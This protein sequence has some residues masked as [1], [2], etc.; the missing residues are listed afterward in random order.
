MS[1]D[2]LVVGINCYQDQRLPN[3]T[4]P[5]EDAEAIAKILEKYGDFK[6]WRLP[7]AI[8]QEDGSSYVGKTPKAKVSKKELETALGQLFKPEGRSIP[9]TA[10]FYFS[11]HGIRQNH[12]LSEGFLATSDAD[13]DRG[14][15]GVSLQWLR[16]LL[17]SSP[18]KQQIIWLDCCYSGELLNLDEANP[19]ERGIAR[20]RCFIA[21][22]REFEK[23]YESIGSKYSVLTK[24]LLEGIDPNPFPQR[25]LTTIDL[26]SYINQNLKLDIQRPIYTNFG[27]P[28]K[29]THTWEVSEATSTI[30]AVSAICPYKGLAYFD[31]NDED[32]KYFYGRALLTNQLLDKVRQSNFLALVG[33]SG[34]G[35]SSVLRAG[36]LHQLKLGDCIGGS[37]AWE[38]NI[39]VPG[40]HPLQNLALTFVDPNLDR[41]ER[42]KKLGQAEGLLKEGADG[43]RHLVLSSDAPRL[44]LVVDQFEESFTLCQ[45]ESERKNFFKCLLETLEPTD[46]KYCLVIAM[47]ADFLGKCLEQD[48]S[49]LAKKIEQNLVTVTPM[50][51]AQLRE[52]VIKP[53]SRVGIEIEPE[54]VEQIIKDV[55][56]SPGSLP[57]LEYTLTQLWSQ[58][59]DNRLGLNAYIKIGGVSGALDKR[60]TE[61]YEQFLLPKQK[62][63]KQVQSIAQ[64]KQETV[65]HIFLCLTQLGEGTEDTRRRVAQTDLVTDKHPI[66]L[67]EEVIQQLAKERLVITSELLAKGSPTGRITV[68][69][70][71]HEALIRN[72]RLLRQWL[73][74]SRELLWQQ[75]KI[76]TAAAEWRDREKDKAKDYL[77]RGKRLKEARDF[78]KEQGERFPLSTSAKNFIKVSLKQKRL[79]RFKAS[80]IFLV[81]PIIGTF[82]LGYEG[83][84]LIHKQTLQKCKGIKGDCP[85]RI[86]ALE[87]LTQANRSLANI[88]LFRA[89]LGGADLSGADLSGA[90][91]SSADLSGA[92]LS[93]ANFSGARLSSA[94]LS[95]ADLSSANLSDAD[96]SSA[97]FYHAN[98]SGADLSDAFLYK[99][100]LGFANL[101]G[102]DLKDA[103][104]KDIKINKHTKLDGKWRRVWEIVNQ[105]AKNRNL[106]G[107]DLS[108]ANLYGDLSGVDLSGADLS[109]ANLSRISLFSA[110]LSGADLSG[111]DLSSA[112]LY[113]ADLSGADLSGADLSGADL[114]DTKLR[115]TKLCDA[116]LKDADLKDADLKD[117]KI[118]EHTKLDGKWRRVWEIANE[119]AKNRNLSGADLSGA[120]LSGADLSGAD[121][122]DA[123]LKDANLSGANLRYADLSGANLYSANFY[124]AD[125]SN[126]AL[127]YADLRRASL[128]SVN[129]SGTNLSGAKLWSANL[130]DTKINEHTNLDVKWRRV[131]EIVNQGAKNRNLS[132]ADLSGANLFYGDLSGVDLSGADLS[133]ANLSHADLSHAD[134]SGADL[135]GARLSSANLS[136]ANFSA[137]KL[138]YAYLKYTKINEHTKFDG[139][140]RRVWEIV[141][142]GAKNRNLSGA[143]LSR[144][145]LSDTNFYSADLS[146]AYLSGADLSGA[147][148]SGADLSGADL[149][150]AYLS[151]AYL[152][153]TKINENTKLDGKWRKVWEI[154][155]QGAKNRNL[156]G[157]DLSGTQLLDADLSGAQL[158]YGDL[159][160]TNFYYA[161]LSGADLSGA[162]L[163]G[164]NFYHAD[165]SG[166]NLSGANLSSAKLAYAN[167]SS[168]DLR[169]ADLRNAHFRG[170]D[171]SSANLSSAKLAHADLRR[172][173]LSGANLS[174]AKLAYADLS[175]ASLTEANLS[176]ANLSGADFRSGLFGRPL[177]GLAPEQIKKAK[178][179]EKAK[180]DPE[181]RQQLGLPPESTL[182]N[183]IE[184]KCDLVSRRKNQINLEVGEE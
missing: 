77:L 158:A 156:S 97:N 12:I 165:L 46:N 21:A 1:R 138:V 96:L 91:L 148:L 4:A 149:S 89:D 184:L 58:Q 108:G 169:G 36:L 119:G 136:D 109:G 3:L 75:R 23:S 151:G 31:C 24:F 163:S 35:K 159:S 183:W 5:A 153:D 70:V 47:R 118:N 63:G 114:R 162:D 144:A 27:E 80:A 48:Y 45:N 61:V 9:D 39:M 111:A 124:H 100:D 56:G 49:G 113:G 141:N 20:D 174:S 116:D 55:K 18:V 25:W 44:V 13:P 129:L 101:S 92:D 57:L 62:I 178:N 134:L 160:D 59:T 79:N 88:N 41:L 30:E 52:V 51:E 140:W 67:V 121:L 179:W 38:I 84:L 139:K 143:E 69:D 68:I 123:Y 26:T 19:G 182:G 132:G 177:K 29:L 170:A 147:Y 83:I 180:Y 120:D 22:S 154:V 135:S 112:N 85:G 64:Q 2:A 11:G 130:K 90:R 76:E 16:R 155:N 145:D 71:A 150:G 166:A 110:K 98:L 17:Q 65:K 131:W 126:A 125:L 34:S 86:E 7:E 82:F 115:D 172:A 107:A 173:D 32:P 164:A 8:N 87:G 161:D 28:I 54:L 176:G 146:G 81:I 42:A 171:L 117:T 105:G 103:N 14:F 43:L 167:L 10:L 152:K 37:D 168:V 137:A 60:A 181:F 73:Y 122:K 33:A 127:K 99:A 95:D 72:W 6:V 106:S 133:G 78:Q 175:R 15:N 74:E 93:G 102:A 66:A 53:A 157:T 40:E 142:Q 128:H 104:L 94:N 50:N